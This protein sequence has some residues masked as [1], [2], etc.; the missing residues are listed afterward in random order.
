[1]K[2]LSELN[3]KFNELTEEI[4]AIEQHIQDENFDFVRLNKKEIFTDSERKLDNMI[5]LQKTLHDAL[6]NRLN[7]LVSLKG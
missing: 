6:E 2:N 5:G 4:A 1:M 7:L 3:E